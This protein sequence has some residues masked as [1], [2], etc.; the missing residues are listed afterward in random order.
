MV[1]VPVQLKADV[2]KF[3]VDYPNVAG[4]FKGGKNPTNYVVVS[5]HL[6]HLGTHLGKMYP[7]ADDNGSG[8][9]TLLELARLYAERR[10][11]GLVS[12]NT[13]I[14]LWFT[15]EESGL[16]GS[17]YFGAH[18]FLSIEFSQSQCRHDW[19][20]PTYG[21]KVDQPIYTLIGSDKLSTELHRLSEEVNNDCC[22]IELD[23]TY[24]DRPIHIGII[25]APIITT[26]PKTAFLVSL[27]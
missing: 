3:P 23:Y 19:I 15:G 11:A 12:D 24:N 14:F 9:A 10:A 25:T 6:D 26:L 17:Q 7:G 4:V 20:A 13:V 27:F 2:S 8:S 16:L 21:H 1:A 22:Q 18:Q 5:A